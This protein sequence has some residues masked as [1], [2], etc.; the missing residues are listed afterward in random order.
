MTNEIVLFLAISLI[1]FLYSSV[2]HGGASGYLALLIFWGFAPAETRSSALIL[3]IIVSGIAFFCYYTSVRVQLKKILPFLMGSVPAAFAG[4]LISTEVGLY[5]ILLGIVL[6][7]AVVRMIMTLKDYQYEPL[8][9]P[10]LWAFVSGTVIGFISGLIGI[11]GGIILSPL[12]ILCRWASIREAACLSALFIFVNS[13]TGL[14]GIILQGITLNIFLI[15]CVIAAIAG[16]VAGS[17][18][19][20]RHLPVP[21]IKFALAMVLLFA[22]FKLFVG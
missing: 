1:A 10:F 4:S 17:W 13:T 14:A 12:L 2:G 21:T 5:K 7:I 11:G 15:P 22:S 8:K 20:S 9:V 16:G 3:N 18:I 19:G 6:L